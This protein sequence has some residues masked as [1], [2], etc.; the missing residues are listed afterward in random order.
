MLHWIYVSIAAVLAL[1][2]LAEIFTEKHW[3]QQL[4]LVLVLIPL[5]L[6]VLHIK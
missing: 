1:L 2:L 6:R 3:K 4:A 5:V